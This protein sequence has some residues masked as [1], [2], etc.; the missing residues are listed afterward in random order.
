MFAR[1]FETIVRSVFPIVACELEMLCCKLTILVGH[2]FLK[3][4][5]MS[6]DN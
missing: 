5:E 6:T 2:C 3:V 1:Y 4:L